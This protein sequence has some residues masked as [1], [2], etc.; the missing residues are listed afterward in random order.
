MSLPLACGY[1]K[2]GVLMPL[3][4]QDPTRKP[5]KTAGKILPLWGKGLHS[6]E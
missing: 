4:R 2:Q 5:T 6:V 1:E 3:K